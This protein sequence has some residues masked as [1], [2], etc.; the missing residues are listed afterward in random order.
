MIETGRK[1]HP[2]WSHNDQS[3]LFANSNF[4]QVVQV[5]Q[6]QGD[7][8]NVAKQEEKHDEYQ[9]ASKLGFLFLLT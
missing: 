3:I 2:E 1:N 4:V 5:V 9:N 6:S 8:A 7:F